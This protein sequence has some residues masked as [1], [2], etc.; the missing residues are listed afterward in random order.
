M[1]LISKSDLCI[2]VSLSIV[3]P[4]TLTNTSSKKISGPEVG[5]GSEGRKKEPDLGTFRALELKELWKL[6][7]PS[8]GK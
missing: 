2:W 3:Q 5:G 6:T 8:K 4:P 1:V 7:C